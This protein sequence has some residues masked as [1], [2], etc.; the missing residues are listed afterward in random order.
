[1]L[2]GICCGEQLAT[3]QGSHVCATM[4]PPIFALPLYHCRNYWIRQA[5]LFEQVLDRQ[6]QASCHACPTTHCAD[7]SLSGIYWDQ[8]VHAI[9][10]VHISYKSAKVRFQVSPN[11]PA[12]FAGLITPARS[13]FFHKNGANDSRRLSMGLSIQA[14]TPLCFWAED[15][16]QNQT[17]R[18]VDGSDEGKKNEERKLT[19]KKRTRWIHKRALLPEKS[20]H[21]KSNVF[22]S[23]KLED[24]GHGV[25]KNF[26]VEIEC[27]FL[28]KKVNWIYRYRT[29]A[30]RHWDRLGVFVANVT[31]FFLCGRLQVLFLVILVLCQGL[32]TVDQSDT[33]Y[34]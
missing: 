2:T 7:I 4:K 17:N 16:W 1:M 10:T 32:G 18:W 25:W 27:N 11:A 22:K 26:L 19:K 5:G 6:V 23:T 14:E 15:L 9:I 12:N 29:K 34:T 33:T 20:F 31:V 13:W 24:K 3:M 21:K 28:D 8:G 30:R